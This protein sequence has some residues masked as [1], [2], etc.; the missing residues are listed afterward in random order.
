[1][2]PNMARRTSKGGRSSGGKAK[3]SKARTAEVEVVEESAGPGWE[4]GVAVIT[5]ILIHVAILIV[6]KGLGSNYD[7]GIF[8]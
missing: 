3:K 2:T 8:F 6:D 7:A 1:M 4:E 5:A